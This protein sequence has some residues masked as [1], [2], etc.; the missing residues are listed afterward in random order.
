MN[1]GRNTPYGAI[2]ISDDAIATVAGT[3]A[4]ECYGVVGLAGRS[5]IREV[6]T[7]LLKKDSYAKGV[8]VDRD[9]GGYIVDVYLVIAYNVKI[10]EVLLEV[11]KKVRYVLERTFSLPLKAVNVYASS[12]RKLS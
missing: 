10:T 6:I 8:S 11:Q 1:I 3:A 7:E 9:K 12:L 4:M 2:D 5:S